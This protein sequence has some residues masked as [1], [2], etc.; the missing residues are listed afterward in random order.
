MKL[1]PM[2]DAEY[3]EYLTWIIPD[4]A[5]DH[6]RAGNWSAEEAE[7]KSAAEMQELL[8]MGR[9]HPIITSIHCTL[10]RKLS[11]SGSSGWR[12][13]GGDYIHAP[14]STIL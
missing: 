2:T 10:T 14:S 6:V 9:A 3:A 4:Y 8:P 11:L 13:C 5:A 7:A 12:C 1:V